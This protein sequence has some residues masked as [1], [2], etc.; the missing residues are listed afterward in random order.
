MDTVSPGSRAKRWAAPFLVAAVV[1]T[2]GV[3]FAN[4]SESAAPTLPSRTAEQLL[5]DVQKADVPGLSGTVVETARLGLPQLPS[6]GGGDTA[7]P[8]KL[9]SGSNTI[10]V[11]VANPDKLRL[12]VTGSLAETDLIANGK[13]VWLYQSSGN[14]AT[15]LRAPAGTA[16]EKAAEANPAANL[17]PQAA[18][19][20]FVDAVSPSTTVTV[21]RTAQVAGRDAYQLRLAPKDSRS[22]I[23]AVVIAVDGKTSVPLRVQVLAKGKTAPALETGF[24]DV[25]FATPDASTFAFTPP[26]GAK[27][28]E[29]SAKADPKDQAKAKEQAG[30]AKDATSG[31]RVFGSD[32]TSVI[33]QPG[34]TA[35]TLTG[36]GAAKQGAEQGA[37]TG[38]SAGSGD[39]TLRTLLNAAT[40]VKGAFGSGRLLRTAL[41]SVLLTDDGRVYAGAVTPETVEA[42]AAQPLTAGK[43]LA[44]AHADKAKAGATP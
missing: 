29:Q 24:T 11:W 22:L 33:A 31:T 39:A 37:E 19:K 25:Q 9:I 23:S 20:R 30:A 10:R 4:R 40:P 16:T 17:T 32:W 15:H 8:T 44:A 38:Q 3:A 28:T 14:K 2:G 41:V 34:V 18:A 13:D 26:P 36:N 7:S 12:A 1:A 6:T 5:A 43:S 35:G 21:D 27:V 42:A